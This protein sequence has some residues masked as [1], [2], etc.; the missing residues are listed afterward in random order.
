MIDE[1][2]RKFSS[3]RVQDTITLPWLIISTKRSKFRD[4]NEKKMR[5]LHN[6]WITRYGTPRLLSDNDSRYESDYLRDRC[7]DF[8]VVPSFTVPDDPQANACTETVHKHLTRFLRT[9]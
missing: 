8:G 6:G 3:M 2:A 5:K 9:S 7:R 1:V 4:L